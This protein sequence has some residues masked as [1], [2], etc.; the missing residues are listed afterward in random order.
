MMKMKHPIVR[1][2]LWELQR[3]HLNNYEVN[4]NLNDGEI[5]AELDTEDELGGPCLWVTFY[6]DGWPGEISCVI[7]PPDDKK[8]IIE[9]DSI[10][11]PS[12]D[13]GELID[14]IDKHINKI[15][16]AKTDG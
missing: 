7:D 10:K 4:I 12:F 3:R 11:D 5:W 14:L 13:P 9:I 15:L 1:A 6:A 2:M 16:E 8:I